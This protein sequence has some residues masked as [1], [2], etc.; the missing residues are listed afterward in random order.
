MNHYFGNPGMWS[1]G[2][3]SDDSSDDEGVDEYCWEKRMRS[4]YIGCLNFLFFP[5]EVYRFFWFIS[6]QIE[7]C[8]FETGEVYDCN[9][10]IVVRNREEELY[11]GDDWYQFAR[12]KRLR[13]G[14]RLGFT[15]SRFPYM[16]Y[17]QLLNR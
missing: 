5:R 9:I 10:R 11:I 8:D 7:M 15:L 17:V 16:L 6:P 3:S 14:D 13:R 1:S 4:G 12:M 2:S